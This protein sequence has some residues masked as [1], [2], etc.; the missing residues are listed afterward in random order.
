MPATRRKAIA[1]PAP[2]TID[3]ATELLGRYADML[4]RVEQLRADADRSIAAIQAARDGFIA[5]IEEE[6]KGLFL[7]LRAWWAVAGPTL[8]DGKRKSYELAGCLLGARTTPPSLKMPVKKDEDAAALLKAE[9]LDVFCR[10]KLSVDKPL[11]L[12]ELA[13]LPQLRET[14]QQKTEIFE[15]AMALLSRVE[16]TEKASGLGFA[17]R[18]KEE[19]FID[20]AAPKPETPEVVAD[21]V[22][23]ELAA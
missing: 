22:A 20:R 15:A 2:Q 10:V 6:A 19:F 21:P 7:Q 11:L 8:T 12:K 4:T 13:A 23:Q 18:Q 9:G 1:Q 14:L 5:P 3:E 16:W 17:P